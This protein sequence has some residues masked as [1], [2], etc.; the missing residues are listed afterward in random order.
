MSRYAALWVSV[1]LAL[2]VPSTALA[3]TVGSIRGYVHDEQGG[4]LP[5]VAITASSPAAATPVTTVTDDHGYYRLLNVLPGIYSVAAELQGFSKFIRENVEMR[6]GLN[7]G[8]DIMLK[9][10]A[11]NETINVKAV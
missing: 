5:G 3:Q 1:A 2:M 7:V 9:I 11:L 6:A 8:V 4:A 10:G